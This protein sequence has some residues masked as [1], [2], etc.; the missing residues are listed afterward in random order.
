M[1]SGDKIDEMEDRVNHE[2]HATAVENIEVLFENIKAYGQT[3]IDLI[4][5][6]AADKSAE[7]VSSAVS[8]VVV[9]VVMLL[10]VIILS[11]GIALLLGE[12]LGKNYYGF[13]TL[14]GIYLIIGLLMSSKKAVWFKAPIANM[15]VKKMFK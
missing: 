15:M 8:A 1:S 6:K 10:F 3:N 11:V 14:A 7:I 12:L 4:K 5:L 9:I 2:G 13:F